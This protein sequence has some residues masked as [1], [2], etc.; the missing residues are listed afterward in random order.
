[1][2]MAA[3][4][5]CYMSADWAFVMAFRRLPKE[6]SIELTKAL[7]VRISSLIDSLKH[8]S[9]SHKWSESID[10]VVDL[11]QVISF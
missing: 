3:T 11:I 7:V 9:I 1:M 4:N 2:E 8:F 6:L 5:Q 10:K